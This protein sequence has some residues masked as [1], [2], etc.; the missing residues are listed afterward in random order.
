MK[1]LLKSIGLPET[2]LTGDRNDLDNEFERHPQYLADVADGLAEVRKTLDAAKAELDLVENRV[3]IEKVAEQAGRKATVKDI[4][5]A[6]LIDPEVKRQARLVRA[7][8]YDLKRWDGLLSAMQAKTSA[9]KHL[10]ELYQAGY[11]T[12]NRSTAPRRSRRDD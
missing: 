3:R 8:E 11:Y 10:S 12:T 5:S 9:L 4:D 6:V 2:L 7:L 1:D